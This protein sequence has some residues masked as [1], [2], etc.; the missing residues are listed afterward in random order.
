M[1]IFLTMSNYTS[2]FMH[3][4]RFQVQLFLNL[5]NSLVNLS[6]RIQ[7]SEQTQFTNFFTISVK[8]FGPGRLTWNPFKYSIYLEVTSDFR[9]NIIQYIG[10]VYIYIYE[11]IMYL[12][13]NEILGYLAEWEKS[14]ADIDGLAS[15]QNME[16]LS[17]T[18][19]GLK[20]T[21]YKCSVCVYRITT[22]FI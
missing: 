15:I 1:L 12:L 20:I 8:I 4:I 7:Q 6:H 14:V 2:C 10:T 9:Y 16:L 17:E 21:T 13:K 18:I 5:C 22:L 3:I 11:L 19:T